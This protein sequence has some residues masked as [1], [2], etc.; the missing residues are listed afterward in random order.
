MADIHGSVVRLDGKG[1]IGSHGV[2]R[3]RTGLLVCLA[4]IVGSFGLLKSALGEGF[5]CAALKGDIEAA[6]YHEVQPKRGTRNVAA[7]IIQDP[8]AVKGQQTVL[9]FVKGKGR[10][11]NQSAFYEA[12]M[13]S[14][15][16]AE[17]SEAKEL[18]GVAL[19]ELD[20][21]HLA[22]QF[23][24]GMPMKNGQKTRGL[25]SLLARS[26]EIIDREMNCRRYLKN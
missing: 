4:G 25:L 3:R 13:S 21:V 24:Y 22:V 2:F 14:E 18:L 19:S 1:T 23:T 5:R 10:L 15:A 9:R 17:S 7:L 12:Q 20:K 11:N 6:V 26:G 8:R 16:I